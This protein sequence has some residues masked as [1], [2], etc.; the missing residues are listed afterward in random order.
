VGS[1]EQ[2]VI[3]LLMANI[4]GIGP[5]YQDSEKEGGNAMA[6]KIAPV[7]ILLSIFLTIFR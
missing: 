2:N 3:P 5:Y 6:H 1:Y 7:L 4:S